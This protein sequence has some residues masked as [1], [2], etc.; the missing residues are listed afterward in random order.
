[1]WMPV[2]KSLSG[3]AA[4]YAGGELLVYGSVGIARRLRIPLMLIGLTVVSMA[5]S[6]PE[7][8]VAIRSAL[9]GVP[10]LAVG[11]VVG[12][13]IVN[14][15][16]ILAI[17]ALIMP[18]VIDKRAIRHNLVIMI[19]ASGLLLTVGLLFGEVGFATGIVFLTALV[20]YYVYSYYHAQATD[21][22]PDEVLDDIKDV[23][24]LFIGL[25]Y[26]VIGVAALT[27]GA[28][29]LVDGARTIADL[30]GVS[31]VVIGLTVVAIGTSLPEL[32][33]CVIGAMRGHSEI[34]FGNIVGSHTIN[35]LA[36]LGVAA[37]I[38]PI[39]INPTLVR[40]DIPLLFILTILLAIILE[41]RGKLTR[42]IAVLFLGIYVAF[43]ASTLLI[44]VR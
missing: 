12:T 27:L 8:M 33:L 42:A 23:S 40:F 1:M 7:I 19:G 34:A 5:T 21:E 37:M 35:I 24:S 29:W 13:N 41:W 26:T 20:G 18:I 6:M 2:L 14:I 28:H 16:L 38:R 44:I 11:N 4:L 30:Y 17:A 25:L 15:Y 32:T 9:D 3:F 43:V 31:Q 22:H 10:D 39:P 36:V